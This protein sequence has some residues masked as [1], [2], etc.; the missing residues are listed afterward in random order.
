MKNEIEEFIVAKCMANH[1]DREDIPLWINDIIE[2]FTFRE[3]KK[4]SLEQLIENFLH[5]FCTKVVVGDNSEL[6]MDD[7]YYI[8]YQNTGY[9]VPE[10]N[11]FF[12]EEDEFIQ[13]GLINFYGI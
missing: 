11:S 4:L 6:M 1:S 2:E 7:H 10:N 8:E 3:S 13:S 5:A 12:T 9:Y